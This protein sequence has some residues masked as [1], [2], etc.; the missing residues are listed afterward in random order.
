MIS[1]RGSG[2]GF[3]VQ[4]FWVLG[5]KVPFFALRATQGRQDLGL[6]YFEFVE[7]PDQRFQPVGFQPVG[8][9]AGGAGACAA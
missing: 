9:Q 7:S 4:R 5:S 3:W 8:F 1:V 6:F 2:L